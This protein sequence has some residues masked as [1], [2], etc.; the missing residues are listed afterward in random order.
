MLLSE[1]RRE[2]AAQLLDEEVRRVG[3]VDE[4]E[5]RER[6]EHERHEREQREVRHHRGEVGAAVGEELRDECPLAEA[7]RR[8]FRR[9]VSRQAAM[10]AAQALA[11]LTEISSQIEAAVLFDESGAV[12]GSTLADDARGPGARAGRR[13][14][15]RACRRRSA[16]EGDGHAARG[17]DRGR[18]ASSSS[19][20]APAGSRRRPAR[21]RRSGLVFYD[22][23]SCLRGADGRAGEAE[24]AAQEE[25]R[26]MRRRLLALVGFAHRR[27]RRQ[28][29]LPPLVRAGAATASTSTSTT[30]RWSR[31]SRARS[32]AEQLLPVAHDALAAA[33]SVSDRSARRGARRARVPRGRLPAPLRQALALLPRQVPLRD[34]ARA[35][36]AA[37]RA[38]RGDRARARARRDAAR[39]AGARRGRARGGGL[40]RRPACR[41]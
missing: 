17:L 27:L 37:R 35:A 14:P 1:L 2:R 21:R 25:G 26:T 3:A 16:R 8:E 39:G 30:A 32:E 18:A 31:S 28:R 20:T 38:D 22:L 5:Q 6:E 23:K 29:R 40:A 41:S 7:H 12:R 4:A 10:D 11:D 24:A 34:A 9:R 13:R 33:R 19:A 36:A 15:A